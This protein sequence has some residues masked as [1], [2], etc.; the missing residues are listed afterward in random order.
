MKFNLLIK[1]C[2]PHTLRQ[3]TKLN[4]LINLERSKFPI[5]I[6]K[7]LRVIRYKVFAF[8][9][10][11]VHLL[12]KLRLGSKLA[13]QINIGNDTLITEVG[14]NVTLGAGEVG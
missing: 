5:S 1:S 3:I 13:A 14:C 12:V 4:S 7:Y 11:L 2:F 10:T 8:S 6:V 9:R